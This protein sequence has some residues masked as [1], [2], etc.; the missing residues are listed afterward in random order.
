MFAFHTFLSASDAVKLE[1]EITAYAFGVRAV[2][3]L[4]EDRQLGCNWINGTF[5]PLDKGEF[6]TYNLMMPIVE[7]YP[8]TK[9]DIEVRLYDVTNPQTRILQFCTLVEGE[10]VLS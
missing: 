1:P 3:E 2:Y 7:E 9:V 4:P 10:V 5:C 8:Q 6:V